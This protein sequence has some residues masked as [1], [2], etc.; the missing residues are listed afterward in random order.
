MV[1]DR[2]RPLYR[3]RSRP[4]I[5]A[6][7]D[8]RVLCHRVRGEERACDYR[9]KVMLR[10]VFLFYH[11]T[12][13]CFLVLSSFVSKGRFHWTKNPLCTLGLLQFFSLHYI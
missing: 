1:C 3:E 11:H 5:Y 13:N 9:R 7:C 2:Q 4:R 10:V 12:T 6:L 8:E